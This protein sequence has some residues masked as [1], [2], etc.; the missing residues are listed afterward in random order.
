MAEYG[1]ADVGYGGHAFFYLASYWKATGCERTRDALDRYA[2]FLSYFVHPDGTVGGEYGSRNTEFYYP[3]GFELF[4][5]ASPPSAAIA[6]AMRGAL[7]SRRVCGV[8]SVDEFNLM[9]MLNN[10]LFALDAAKPDLAA[11]PLPFATEPFRR[12]FPEAGLWVVN[13]AAYYAVV[14]VSKGGTVSVFDKALRRHGARF[15]G[16][17]VEHGGERYTSQDF[18]VSPAATYDEHDTLETTV[19]WKSLTTRV[20]GPLLFVAF[21][22]FT[23]TAGRVPAVSRWL[24]HTLVQS[25]IARKRRP[26]VRHKRTLRATAEGISTSDELFLPWDSGQLHA[27]AQFTAIHMGSSLYADWRSAG[28]G[29]AVV[30]WPVRRRMSLHAA[31]TTTGA[32]WRVESD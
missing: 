30:T 20:F 3:A 13:E 7:R 32:S 24:K 11:P 23:M 10:V 31:L 28:P 19:S 21:R 14:G 8:W 18:Q 2:G 6:A 25:L 26:A 16:L 1:G 5:A 4:A 22:L 17:I 27:V 12:Y 29:P 15:S 9:P